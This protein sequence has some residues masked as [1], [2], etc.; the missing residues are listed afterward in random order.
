MTMP[1]LSADAVKQQAEAAKKAAKQQ[2]RAAKKAARAAARQ[3]A[4][5][6]PAAL[7]WPPTRSDLFAVLCAFVVIYCVVS[8]LWEPLASLALIICVFAV[9]FP[10]MTGK[11]RVGGAPPM[12]EGEFERRPSSPELP[13]ES[14]PEKESAGD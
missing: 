3:R 7:S 12:V 1:G 10:R 6:N 8:D 11:W 14:A 4:R 13:P 2:A 5:D 9:A